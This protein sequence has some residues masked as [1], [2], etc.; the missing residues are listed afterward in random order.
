MRLSPLVTRRCA[1]AAAMLVICGQTHAQ[2]A[3]PVALDAGSVRGAQT[4]V[5]GIRVFA[6]IPFAAPPVGDLRWRMPQPVEAWDGVRD[7]TRFGNICIQPPGRGR[8]NIAVLP[9]SPPMSEDC[10]YLNV[11]TPAASAEDR[12]AV[13]VYFYGGAWTEGAGSIPLYDGTA[14][15]EK[16]V[17]VVTM[18]YRLGPF[19]FFAHPALTADSGTSSSG[20]Y[21]LGDKIAAL[22]WVRAN[23]AA[24]GGDPENV[25]VFGQS[26]GA[27]SIA[28]LVASPLASGLFQRAISQSG[29]WMGLS[30]SNSMR[31]LD[32][33]QEAGAE[34]AAAAG[35]DTAAGLRALSADEVVRHLRGFG[36]I[37]DGLVV[38]ED[39]NE[40]FESGRQNAVDV[41]TGSNKNDSFFAPQP[42]LDAFR[43]RM[44]RQWDDL[45]DRYFRLYPAD[46]GEQAASMTSQ[47]S[48]D[49]TFWISRIFAEYQH[50]LGKRAWVYQ[51]AQNPPGGNGP[52]FPASHA[53][54]LPYVFDNLGQLPLFPDGSTAYWSGHSETDA[55]VADQM[56][57]FWTN[58]ARTGDPNGH[59]LPR[60]PEHSGL[61]AVDAIILDED[62]AS[63]KLPT[64]ERMQ[65]FDEKYYHRVVD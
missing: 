50:Q 8:L 25:T 53:A 34:Q 13:M 10:L 14:L 48:N 21:G 42:D 1:A 29:T 49:G 58:F 40:V 16:G 2:I 30:P 15:A 35:V 52:D 3:D 45:A 56:S 28:T 65:L 57:S 5:D 32:S 4:Q 12:L 37:V 55:R 33:A 22:R 63:E 59:G 36:V 7:A 51:F 44:T 54:E 43:E 38:P 26:A 17:V 6:G 19:G 11:W 23:I 60:W 62:P 64:L 9:E 18:N 61:D 24:F 27:A 20:N 39:P 46:T 31:K 41:L 47:T